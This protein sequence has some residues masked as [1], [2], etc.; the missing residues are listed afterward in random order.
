MLKIKH[1]EDI[2]ILGILELISMLLK[3]FA[4]EKVTTEIM[5]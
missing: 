5:V 4:I 3:S 2:E 1:L